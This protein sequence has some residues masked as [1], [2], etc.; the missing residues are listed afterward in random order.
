METITIATTDGPMDAVQSSPE[1]APRGAVIVIQ[2]AFGLTDHIAD[3]TARLAAEG[4]TAVAPALFHRQGSAVVDYQAMGTE[5]GA[6]QIMGLLGS[7][8]AEGLSVDLDAT[9]AH[10]NSLGFDESSIGMV[11]FCMGGAVTLFAA[12]RPGISA[13]VTFYGGGVETGRF[14]LPPLIELAPSL[15]CDWLGLYGDTDGSIPVE[16]V[17]ALRSAAAS[18]PVATE[19]VRYPDAGHGFNCNDRPDH[20]D[21]AAADDAWRRTITFF[22]DHLCHP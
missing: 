6:K 8:S 4:F 22:G 21:Q 1:G 16:Q 9:I 13:G 15:R 12:T 7:L 17:E 19:I 20:F 10:L 2:E 18:A 3:I 11:G 14:G 5:D